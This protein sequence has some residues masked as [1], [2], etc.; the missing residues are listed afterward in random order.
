MPLKA[1]TRHAVNIFITGL[2]AA[3]P[4]AATVAIFVAG[5]RMLYGWLGPGSFVGGLLSSLGLGVTGSE[6]AGYGIGVAIV[7]GA[8]FALGLLVQTRLRPVL[9]A[10]VDNVVKRIP[11]VRNVYDTL[12]KFIDLLSKRDGEGTRSMSP[13]WLTFGGPGNAAVLGLLA[14]PEPVQVG[15]QPYLG[16]IVPTAPVPV[17]GA[18]LYVPQAWVSPAPVGMD[19]LTS[20]YVSMGVT[21]PQHLGPDARR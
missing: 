14:S 7:V 5:A 21:G 2:V 20:I 17:G 16:V 12:R 19:G 8:I 3:L 6:V 13:V 15:G 9:M 11:L 18:L 4:L 1:T 10:A